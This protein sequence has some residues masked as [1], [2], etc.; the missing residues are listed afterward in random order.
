MTAG[1]YTATRIDS[2]PIA[3][4]FRSEKENEMNAVLAV[5]DDSESSC[6]CSSSSSSGIT[7]TS[8]ILIT[9]RRSPAHAAY[10]S[11]S[12][13]AQ[14]SGRTGCHY[15]DAFC[16]SL[17][18]RQLDRSHP[19]VQTDLLLGSALHSAV[20]GIQN[21]CSFIASIG[22]RVWALSFFRRLTEQ[23]SR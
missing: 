13:A 14:P 10:A 7:W 22:R 9:S 3:K 15:K 17:P 18:I 6:S 19:A 2:A 16:A 8:S 11:Q 5:I 23:V 21:R 1:R 20:S 12:G 4:L